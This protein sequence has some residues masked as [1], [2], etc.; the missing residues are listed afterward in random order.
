MP[1]IVTTDLSSNQT[2]NPL[3]ASPSAN[4][5]RAQPDST[6]LLFPPRTSLDSRSYSPSP[7][8][9]SS[10]DGASLMVPP[11][12]TLSAQSSGHFPTSLSLRDNE[13]S[14]CEPRYKLKY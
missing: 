1:E 11:S 4:A 6:S 7:T 12:P 2:V 3:F 8:V 10:N 9:V 5:S 14:G 13:R